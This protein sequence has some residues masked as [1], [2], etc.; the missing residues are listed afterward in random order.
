MQYNIDRT[1]NGETIQ[2]YLTIAPTF[3]VAIPNRISRNTD[4]R[5]RK[6]S[7]FLSL[8]KND[9]I[10]ES[11]RQSVKKIPSNDTTLFMTLPN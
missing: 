8:T 5:R 7:I 9:P 2:R 11:K 3:G 1:M 4:E 6:K 10:N